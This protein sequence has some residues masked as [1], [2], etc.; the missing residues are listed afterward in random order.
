MKNDSKQAPELV[1]DFDLAV[2]ED[3]QW[4]GADIQP[5]GPLAAFTDVGKPVLHGN[6]NTMI[7]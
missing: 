2:I 1:G 4:A 5:C 3:C 6:Q 7:V